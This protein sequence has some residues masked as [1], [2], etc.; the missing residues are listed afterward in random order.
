MGKTIP[1]DKNAQRNNLLRVW[2]VHLRSNGVDDVTIMFGG[3][4]CSYV[5]TMSD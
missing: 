5:H 3:G 4:L 2:K 1:E